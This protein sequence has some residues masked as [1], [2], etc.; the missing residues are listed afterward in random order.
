MTL[1]RKLAYNT[2]I[3]IGARLMGVALSLVT[4]GFI[5]R[6]LGKDGFGGYSL[7]M[8]FLYIFDNLADLGLYSLMIREISRSEI[9]EKKVVSNIFTIRVVVVLFLLT[10]A[11][12]VVWLFPY[13]YQVKS[14][15]MLAAISFL[16]LSMGQV[17]MGIFQ[18]YLKTDK[19]A[20]ADIAGR[21]SQFLMVV[22][23]MKLG[24][25]FYGIIGS[26][27]LGCLINFLLLFVF[28]R[29]Y[30]KFSLEFDFAYWKKLIRTT[31]PI[32][33]SIVLTLIYFKI[34]SIFLSIPL[35]NKNS[36][37][38]I[39]DV[40]IY[41]IAYKILEGLIFFPSMFIGLIMPLLSSSAFRDRERFK[42]IYQKTVDILFM[43]VIPLVIGIIM[44]SGQIVVL[45]GGN[46]FSAS[47]GPLNILAIAIGLIFFGTL[48]G[49]SIIALDRQKVGAWIYFAGMIFNIVTNLI[50]IPKYQYIG[51]AW[52]TVV[53]ELLVTIL[54]FI[55]VC[56]TIRYFP[57]FNIWKPLIASVAM[58]GFV[59]LFKYWNVFLLVVGALIVY[60]VT[61]YLIKGIKKEEIELL[62][63]KEI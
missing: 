5:A 24:F 43:L 56:K 47:A 12:L 41:G 44:L 14:G 10:I 13:S 19:S 32:A 33:A 17:L 34:D 11:C 6:Y 57:R 36:L 60:I 18:K 52:T 23:V 20:I 59:H 2:V 46:G 61:L 7:I 54:M 49:N 40:G 63:K 29:R 48:L 1:V 39:S 62:V 51:A 9:S 55:F 58:A 21:I 30:V 4:L 3:S 27:I 50:F 15:T 22:A 25:G 42:R 26:L 8:A 28:A 37:S 53:T 16:F 38:P 35:I 45:I 31:I